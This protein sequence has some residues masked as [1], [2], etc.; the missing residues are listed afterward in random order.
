MSTQP[1]KL[2]VVGAHP[3]DAF[4]RAGGTIAKHLARGDQAMMV[5][6]TAGVVTHAFGFF[7]PTGDDKLKDIQRVKELKWAEFVRACK[8]L[9][10]TAWKTLDFPE[11]PMLLGQ[12]EYVTMV[13]ILREFRPDVVI[14]QHPIEVGRQDHMD[15]GRFVVAAVDYCRTEGFPSPL[16]PHTVPNLFMSYYQ[17]FRSEQ[18]TG[19]AQ[20]A[21][22]VI[23]DI[24]ATFEKKVEA[25]Q[26][27]GGTQSKG[28]ENWRQ[29][30]RDGMA[31]IDHGIGYYHGL[32]YAEQFTRLNV[33]KVQYLL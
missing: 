16:A 10:A 14:C 26:E 9:G 12:A 31:A 13:N 2:M 21:P 17:D 3:L 18:L 22:G 24:T 6:L 4:E 30:W 19:A 29:E 25:M 15:A 8:V 33:Q 7:P 5:T 20:H 1:I 28:K 32:G 11:S 23:V 27:F